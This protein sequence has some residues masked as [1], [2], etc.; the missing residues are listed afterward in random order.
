MEMQT[1]NRSVVDWGKGKQ[2]EG[3]EGLQLGMQ[4]HLEVM[5]M[6]IRLTEVMV[7]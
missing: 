7:S 6:F 2:W 3:Q 4:K 1:E 5:D